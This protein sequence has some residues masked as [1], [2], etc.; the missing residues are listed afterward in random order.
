MECRVSLVD[1]IRERATETTAGGMLLA[2]LRALRGT[3]P[4]A[5]PPDPRATEAAAQTAS[6]I[7]DAQRQEA[8]WL[9]RDGLLD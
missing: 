7:A 8:Q 5:T 4:R 2:L 3:T 6:A 9:R 1:E